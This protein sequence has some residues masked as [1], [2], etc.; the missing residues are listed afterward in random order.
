MLNDQQSLSDVIVACDGA[1]SRRRGTIVSPV[2]TA[3]AGTVR[4]KEPN[5]WAGRRLHQTKSTH[6][7]SYQVCR[8]PVGSHSGVSPTPNDIGKSG[9]PISGTSQTVCFVFSTRVCVC[10][11]RGYLMLYGRQ[12]PASAFP[13]NFPNGSHQIRN[14]A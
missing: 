14:S 13:A 8:L 10:T 9:Q 7:F 3:A 5:G 6:R 2:L 11:M 4:K 1:S 12:R